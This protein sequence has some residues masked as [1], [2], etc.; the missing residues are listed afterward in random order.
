[1]NLLKQ[2]LKGRGLA[3]FEGGLARLSEQVRHQSA[4]SGHSGPEGIETPP[5]TR[6]ESSCLPSS[7]R[8]RRG[9]ND[10]AR[11]P[12]SQT[13]A[14]PADRDLQLWAI[15]IQGSHVFGGFRGLAPGLSLLAALL[16]CLA[17]G[18]IAQTPTPMAIADAYVQ[19]FEA[20]YRD[21]RSLRAEFSQSYTLSGSPPRI[22]AGRVVFARGGLMRWDYLRPMEKLFVSDGKQA[23]LY[24][25]EEHQLTRSSMKASG[26]FRI[27]FELLLTRLD[28]RR[29]FARVELADASADHEPADHVLR[30]FPKKEFAEVY[31][32]VLIELS[33]QFDM[34]RLLIN[35]PD[36]SRMD[37]HFDHIE[38]NPALPR[39]LF[40]FSPPAGTD[41]ID[42]H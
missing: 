16:C 29:I 36:H 2:P 18:L 12:G 20:S 8:L 26:D 32:D 21:V 17:P 28:L 15:P 39:S 38:R 23:S 33:P 35:Y 24:I 30:A 40:Q 34:R 25:P 19:Q 9:L 41:I 6:L 13:N 37:F 10:R 7:P 31:T 11:F 27:P 14:G 1:M 4:D 5:L 3:K 42:Q 22:E